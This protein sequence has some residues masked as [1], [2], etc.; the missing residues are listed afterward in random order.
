[1]PPK[2]DLSKFKGEGNPVDVDE[3]KPILIA[4]LAM[5]NV[6]RGPRVDI[7]P[8]EKAVLKK[9][10]DRDRTSRIV[11]GGLKSH[12]TFSDEEIGVLLGFLD[13]I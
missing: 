3:L 12:L 5:T 1:M 9:L 7:T 2:F 11:H 10:L 13:R 4:D 8:E 6:D